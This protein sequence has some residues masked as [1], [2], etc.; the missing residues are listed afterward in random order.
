MARVGDASSTIAPLGG[1]SVYFMYYDMFNSIQLATGGVRD[2]AW[3]GID[4]GLGLAHGW[5]CTQFRVALG[6][7]HLAL[8]AKLRLATRSTEVGTRF[9]S[10]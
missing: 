3:S 4:A 5:L 8:G 9:G 7:V 10:T 1:D 6:A 2:A